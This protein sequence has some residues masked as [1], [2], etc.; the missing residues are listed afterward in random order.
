[1]N[2]LHVTNQFLFFKWQ[3]YCFP[4]SNCVHYYLELII[5]GKKT[6][7]GITL[8]FWH[9]NDEMHLI[10]SQ[11]TPQPQQ[12][13]LSSQKPAACRCN[14]DDTRGKWFLETVVATTDTGVEVENVVVLIK[15]EVFMG[16]CGR[17]ME[18]MCDKAVRGTKKHPADESPGIKIKYFVFNVKVEKV[19]CE[20][21]VQRRS[22]TNSKIQDKRF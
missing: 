10:Q 21:S 18:S 5:S 13:P 6:N 4:T 9:V 2:M 19:E 20:G 12:P 1:M 17:K 3:F 15:V 16:W 8:C 11:K 7:F 14:R 22:F